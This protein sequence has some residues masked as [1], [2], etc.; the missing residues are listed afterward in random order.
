MKKIKI[1]TFLG[2]DGSGKST[3]IKELRKY[4][5][6]NKIKNKYIHLI[7]R[8]INKKTKPVKNPHSKEFRS[9]LASFLKLLYWIF[10]FKIFIV[11]ILLE[12]KNF[13][14]IFDRYPHDLLID[15][16]RYRFRL[17]P[18]ITEF[19]LNFMPKPSHCIVLCGPPKLLWRRKKEIDYKSLKSI[20]KKYKKFAKKN[21]FFLLQ[22]NKNK[23]SLLSNL[24]KY[25]ND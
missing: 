3:L 17:N 2:V 1:I 18:N 12:N 23:K 11:K 13:I 22:T 5:K 25:L 7:P 6:T 21:N 14:Y 20:N 19:M 8:L 4:Y 10:L 15:P 16:K 9:E 24:V